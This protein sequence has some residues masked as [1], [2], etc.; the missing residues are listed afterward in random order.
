[1]RAGGWLGIDFGTSS[2]VAVLGSATRPP[3]PLLFDGS[4]LLPSAVCLVAGGDRVAGGRLV[5][6]RDAV[7]AGLAAPMSFEPHPKRH[8]DEGTLLL[9][10]AEVPVA[11]VVAAVLRRVAAEADRVAG[12]PVSRTVLTCPAGWGAGRRGVLLEAARQVFPD[13]VLVPEPVAAAALF[14]EVAGA[15]IGEGACALVYDLGAGTFD[16]SVIAHTTTGRTTTGRTTTGHTTAGR[17]A[18]GFEVVAARGLADAGGLDIDAAIVDHLAAVVGRRD[19]VLWDR[20][21]R[22]ATAADRRARALLWDGVRAAKETLSRTAQTMV[23]V[24]LLDA[25]VPLGREQLEELA[26]PIIERTVRASRR[27]L[28]EAGV[29]AAG[30][31]G[32]FLVGGASRMPLVATALH[33]ALGIAPTAIEAPELAVAQGSRHALPEPQTPN[34]EAPDDEL[35]DNDEADNDVAVPVLPVPAGSGRPARRWYRWGWLA[36]AAVAAALITPVAIR[37][38]GGGD[39]AADQ[40]ANDQ[41]AADQTSTPP[42]ATGS[43]RTSPSPTP[44]IDA[45]LVGTWRSTS[46][47][48][49]NKVNGAPV[50]FT[51]TGGGL[52][53][54]SATGA[55]RDDL[56]GTAPLTATVQGQHL[57]E[58][59][60]GL[61]TS[62]VETDGGRIYRSAVTGHTTYTMKLNGDAYQHGTITPSPT[63]EHY[64]CTAT[65]LRVY[66]SQ[67]TTVSTRV[68]RQP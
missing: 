1:M 14:A 59:L 55:A 29:P 57:T 5:T 44:V 40:N 15:R 32:V 36:A 12:E 30:L 43:R 68:S 46:M 3:Q 11:E 9:G 54:F 2:T 8:L 17:T 6:G 37:A 16:A 41:N 26:A 60:H 31:A 25:E 52:G 28:R 63:P 53:T 48:V 38:A 45:C 67:S 61:T 49:V 65:T 56:G 66:T 50:R 13:P 64:T 7:Q 21:A 19:T 47:Q 23:H 24:P 20:L 22:P 42:A 62:H 18:T 58:V 51:S 4:P 10:E 27:V 39:P 35:P 33:R 34:D